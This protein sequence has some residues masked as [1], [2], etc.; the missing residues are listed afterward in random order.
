MNTSP[1]LS[2]DAPRLRSAAFPV[3]PPRLLRRLERRIGA[4]S[5]QRAADCLRCER[6]AY[7]AR[8]GDIEGARSELEAVRG[9][10]AASTS[11]KITLSIWLHYA[12]ALAGHCTNLS[13][14][15]HG[16]LTRAYALSSAASLRPVQALCAAWMAH[17]ELLRLNSASAARFAAEALVLAPPDHHAALA[18]AKL[19]VAQA[20]HEAG[21]Y[22]RARPWYDGAR[23]HAAAE[24]DEATLAAMLGNMASLRLANWRQARALRGASPIEPN[25]QPVAMSPPGDAVIMT[26]AMADALDATGA[27]TALLAE[28]S[29]NLDALLGVGSLP[30]L[31]PML[32]A[33]ILTECG[34]T[35][36]ALG[37]YDAHLGGLHADGLGELEG[38]LL[39]DR[40]WCLVR[41]G[42]RDEAL[43]VAENALAGLS[44]PGA[45]GDRAPGHARLVQVFDALG[46]ASRAAAQR[47]H[48]TRAWAR[49]AEHQAALI[50][51]FDHALNELVIV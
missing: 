20:Y 28:S 12:E 7:L 40:A 46:D 42:R 26:S 34:R 10:H 16:R 21:H 5:N 33:Q 11:P 45:A 13:A 30:S 48:A 38:L 37:L 43:G 22:D 50:E 2:F 6:A 32:K 25:A 47:L 29:A 49:Y 9:R 14:D 15:A 19:V 3:Q 8:F 18:R 31:Q 4:A 1:T 51:A 27:T 24:G 36:E 35:A 39:A 23:R 44:R 41:G 17:F